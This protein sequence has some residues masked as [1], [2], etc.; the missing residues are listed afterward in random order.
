MG[1]AYSEVSDARF[2]ELHLTHGDLL[3]V[4]STC[5]H[6]G[7]C[8]PPKKIGCHAKCDFYSM[9][10]AQ[11]SP[12]VVK[13]ATHLY[14]VPVP[15]IKGFT[16]TLDQDFKPTWHQGLWLGRASKPKPTKGAASNP[17]GIDA[18]GTTEPQGIR[19][20]RAR[21]PCDQ[22]R[23]AHGDEEQ[24]QQVSQQLVTPHKGNTQPLFDP[25]GQSTPLEGFSIFA[26]LASAGTSPAAQPQHQP[27][28][29]TRLG[30]KQRR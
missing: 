25:K 26:N 15:V 22:A 21:S 29:G 18:G 23:A 20:K 13:N 10:T 27:S 24:T 30:N 12:H 2:V 16:G 4:T 28:K 6:H 17:P 14:L 3:V 5:R 19:T 11:A 8:T 1:S 7:M 9:D